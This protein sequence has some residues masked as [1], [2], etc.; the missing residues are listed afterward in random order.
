[1]PG[2]WSLR[3]FR[4]PFKRGMLGWRGPCYF[5]FPGKIMGSSFHHGGFCKGSWGNIH[6]FSGYQFFLTC[7]AFEK[8]GP[9]SQN[10]GFAN[11]WQVLDMAFCKMNAKKKQGYMDQL[12]KSNLATCFKIPPL[13]PSCQAH[14]LTAIESRRFYS[15]SN[16][17][18]CLVSKN[19]WKKLFGEYARL[20]KISPQPLPTFYNGAISD[21]ENPQ[22]SS[23]PPR[24]KNSRNT[25]FWA[26]SGWIICKRSQS[27]QINWSTTLFW[28][29]VSVVKTQGASDPKL[30]QVEGYSSW[31]AANCMPM[32]EIPFI[33]V[34]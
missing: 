7:C 5:C 25:T 28:P 19:M 23:T 32:V 34:C 2:G 17:P 13:N 33:G 21:W 9:Q 12:R 27:I 18:R 11:P 3:P 15:Q 24:S 1:M 16:I 10:L 31:W 4:V 6:N 26:F 20:A 30:E 29:K 22:T 8:N 14:N